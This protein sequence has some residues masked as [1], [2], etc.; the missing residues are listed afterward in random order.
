MAPVFK[1]NMRGQES[2]HLNKEAAI[3]PIHP[4]AEKEGVLGK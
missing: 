3:A 1:R 4:T 2:L